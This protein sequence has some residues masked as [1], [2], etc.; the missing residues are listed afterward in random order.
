MTNLRRVIRKLILENEVPWAETP[1]GIEFKKYHDRERANNAIDELM[2]IF[3][4][5][6]S[7]E[8]GP[9]G[10]K[11]PVYEMNDEPEPGCIVRIRVYQM[12]GAVKLDEIETTPECEGKGYAK[13]AIQKIKDVV[14]KN[15][16][17]LFLE[18]KAFH[19]HKGEGRMSS[20]ELEGWYASQGF[21]KKG[22]KMEYKW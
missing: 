21:T 12:H 4:F 11:F 1:E 8:V 17:M 16:I 3:D 9:W 6:G 5:Q 19:T 20:S 22:W 7:W 13:A 14:K 18:P 15:K 10:N 2:N